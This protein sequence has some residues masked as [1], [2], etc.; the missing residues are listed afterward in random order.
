ME[1]EEEKII[2]EGKE[3]TMTEF[4]NYICPNRFDSECWTLC[5]IDENTDNDD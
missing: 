2:W 5:Y 1:T 4:C 3:I